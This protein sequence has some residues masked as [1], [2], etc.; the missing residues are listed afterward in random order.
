MAPYQHLD[1]PYD[2][3]SSP[4][5]RKPIFTACRAF[6]V[7]FAVAVFAVIIFQAQ[8]W[9]LLQKIH[10]GQCGGAITHNVLFHDR[11]DLG[12]AGAVGDQAWKALMPPPTADSREGV[13]T[14]QINETYTLP[15]EASYTHALHC[16]DAMRNMFFHEPASVLQANIKK[17]EH[18]GH[19]LSYVAQ[20]V[21]CSADDTI[22]RVKPPRD[23]A[24]N[25]LPEEGD[26][27][28]AR[29]ELHTCR[30]RSKTEQILHELTH[31][32]PRS[33]KYPEVRRE[34]DRL[35]EYYEECP[36]CFYN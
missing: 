15:Y 24:G 9:T 30:D 17:R 13:I 25:Y 7:V 21:L 1:D 16:L 36:G 26:G 23:S 28:S 14:V 33:L 34:V 31:A 4:T 8:I 11:K 22:E 20:H 29:Q 12:D 19:C 2:Y 6:S 10:F 27:Q 32:E 18:M 5:P 35:D 3:E